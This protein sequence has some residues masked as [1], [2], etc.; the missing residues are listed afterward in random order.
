MLQNTPSAP[1]CLSTHHINCFFF[2]QGIE[3]AWKKENGL[4]TLIIA[5]IQPS[6]SIICIYVHRVHSLSLTHSNDYFCLYFL[7]TFFLRFAAKKLF[8]KAQNVYCMYGI[9]LYR[10]KNELTPNQ[11]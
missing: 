8:F 10:Y 7:Y 1:F 9:C 3:H 4:S 6:L 11:F 2:T 5:Y